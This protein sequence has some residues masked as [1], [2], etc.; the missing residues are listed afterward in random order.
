MKKCKHVIRMKVELFLDIPI[1]MNHR[2]NKK[3]FRSKSVRIDGANWP[4]SYSYCEKCG[5]RL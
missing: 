5:V 3:S 4:K 2:L 1:V